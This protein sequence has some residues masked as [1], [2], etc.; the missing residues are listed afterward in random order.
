MNAKEIRQQ[1]I[2][3]TRGH[4]RVNGMN[5]IDAT[6]KDIEF[7]V[8]DADVE[9]SKTASDNQWKLFVREFKKWQREQACIVR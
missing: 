9:F 1:A 3:A 2:Q 8:S 6:E 7:A 4:M 5:P